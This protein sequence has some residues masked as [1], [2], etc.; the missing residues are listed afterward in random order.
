MRSCSTPF[1]CGDSIARAAT[2]PELAAPMTFAGR[3]R[4]RALR[5]GLLLRRRYERHA[6]PDMPTSPGENVSRFCAE[7]FRRIAGRADRASG[8]TPASAACSHDDA[9][10]FVLMPSSPAKPIVAQAFA[11]LDDPAERRELGTALFI[12]RPLGFFKQ[13]AEV[14]ATPL[15]SY[16]AFSETLAAARLREVGRLAAELDLAWSETPG[17][18][19]A[20]WGLGLDQIPESPRPAVSLADARKVAPD[21]R[22]LRTTQS[23]A[24]AF[25]RCFDTRAL[26]VADWPL[27]A[28]TIVGPDKTRMTAIDAAGTVRLEFDVDPSLG[29]LLRGGVEVPRAGLVAENLRIPL[30]ARVH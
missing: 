23:S 6:V 8:P 16:V 28:R 22:I 1:V 29:Y 17:K 21:F 2:S 24:A 14:D 4:R 20:I 26:P 25:W 18:P 11:D 5:Q 12:D 30:S 19:G 9:D 13:P 7:P 27:V 10:R 15:L 3:I